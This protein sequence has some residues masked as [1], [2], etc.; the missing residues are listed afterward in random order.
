M[1]CHRVP[2]LHLLQPLSFPFNQSVKRQLHLV[3]FSIRCC[4]RLGHHRWQRD[5]TIDWQTSTSRRRSDE[6]NSAQSTELVAVATARSLHWRKFRLAILPHGTDGIVVIC[7]FDCLRLGRL[8]AL[9]QWTDYKWYEIDRKCHLKPVNYWMGQPS[10]A[11]PLNLG[12]KKHYFLKHCQMFCFQVP[13]H[14]PKIQLKVRQQ[15]PVKSCLMTF[16]DNC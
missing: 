5:R 3:R 7:V 4:L 11:K 1:K 8:S 13:P 10:T 2:F 15:C 12:V 6:D 16:S 14:L 9:S